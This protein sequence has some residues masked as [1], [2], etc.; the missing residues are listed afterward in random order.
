MLA[1]SGGAGEDAAIDTWRWPVDHRAALEAH[2]ARHPL[3]AEVACAPRHSL[4]FGTMRDREP[5]DSEL[6][7]IAALRRTAADMG[8]PAP[9]IDVAD[10]LLDER[11]IACR[12]TT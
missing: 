1:H 7:L 3:L 11:I 6:R 5:V 8:A 10:E 9:R 4:R 12:P 2:P